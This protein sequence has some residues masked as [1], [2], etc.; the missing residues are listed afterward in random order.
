MKKILLALS[1]SCAVVAA[2]AESWILV[3]EA[4]TGSRLLVDVDSYQRNIKGEDGTMF[5]GALF[6]FFDKGEAGE[7]F[8]FLVEAESCK[9]MNGSLTSRKWNGSKWV[10]T[11][12]YWWSKDG[13]KM[14]DAGGTLLCGAYNKVR[15]EST[16]KTGAT[17]KNMI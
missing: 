17:G 8:A 12:K 11:E 4:D 3:Q 7:P 13:N 14:Y 6:R 2:Q 15:S 1:L 5:V 10:T 16:P 9:S